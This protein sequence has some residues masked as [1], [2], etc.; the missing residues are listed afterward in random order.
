MM[1]RIL[2]LILGLLVLGWAGAAVA[3]ECLLKVANLSDGYVDGFRADRGLFSQRAGFY[4]RGLEQV[5]SL[6]DSDGGGNQAAM[7]DIQVESAAALAAFLPDKATIVGR[8]QPGGA[9]R[10]SKLLVGYDTL[11]SDGG[12]VLE[13]SAPGAGTVSRVIVK[14][15]QGRLA[16]W[17]IRTRGF[18][19]VP[20]K[21]VCRID[22]ALFMQKRNE[23]QFMSWIARVVPR[24]GGIGLMILARGAAQGA[25]RVLLWV[26]PAELVEGSAGLPEAAVVIGWS[27]RTP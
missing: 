1:R 20:Q 22:E 7:V 4:D 12:I 16:G 2:G 17:Q 21:A 5:L 14:D 3:G 9:I 23:P 11:I 18:G 6:G 24:H 10:W 25:D 27:G 19:L 15:S 13:I 26:D 8:Q